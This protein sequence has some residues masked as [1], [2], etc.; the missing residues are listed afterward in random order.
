MV[1]LTVPQLN[2]PA[3]TSSVKFIVAENVDASILPPACQGSLTRMPAYDVDKHLV[4]L[5]LDE[6]TMDYQS[7]MR[8]VPLS[9]LNL[10][11]RAITKCEQMMH[12]ARVTLHS[13]DDHL[14][15]MRE[16]EETAY[17]Q[18]NST[19]DNFSARTDAQFAYLGI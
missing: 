19:D 12:D 3:A 13:L 15:D 7:F 1:S 9:D 8:L 18:L 6:T 2:T 5:Y 10:S 17:A 11:D 4:G 16:L 14:D